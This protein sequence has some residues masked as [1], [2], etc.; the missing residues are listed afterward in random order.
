MSN[1]IRKLKSKFGKIFNIGFK[2]KRLA[3]V[4]DEYRSVKLLHYYGFNNVLDIGANTGQFA[5][6]LF[7]YGFSGQ[8]VSFEPMLEA[9]NILSNNAKNNDRWTV[10]E[11]CA[12][13]N[14]NAFIDLNISRNSVFNSL[15]EV[16]DSYVNYNNDAKVERKEKVPIFTL[17]YFLEKYIANQ[18]NTFLKIDTQGFEKE[19]LE[20]AAESLKFVNGI[21]IEIPL[22][23][24]YKNVEWKLKDFI[25]FMNQLDFDCVSVQPVA[26]N[27]KQGIIHE[28]DAIFLRKNLI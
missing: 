23:P 22:V 13:G 27:I 8:V 7:N 16:N 20:G 14:K 15:K 5:S 18:V 9:Y 3:Y 19:V 6:Q 26:I 21:K 12:I 24:I 25:D 1:L 2:V 4:S 11:R 28:I 10:A 17:D